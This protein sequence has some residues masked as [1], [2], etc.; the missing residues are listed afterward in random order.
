MANLSTPLSVF[1]TLRFKDLAGSFSFTSTAAA[2]FLDVNRDSLQ[3]YLSPNKPDRS[4]PVEREMMSNAFKL[5]RF[6]GS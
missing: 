6:G 4:N 1:V 2:G 5:Y 3:P